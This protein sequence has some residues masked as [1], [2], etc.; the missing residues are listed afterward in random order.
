M[1]SRDRR[2]IIDD[3]DGSETQH[4]LGDL[5]LLVSNLVDDN[6]PPSLGTQKMVDSTNTANTAILN[7]L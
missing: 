3:K 6:K 2:E 4:H 5:C 1:S 7:S